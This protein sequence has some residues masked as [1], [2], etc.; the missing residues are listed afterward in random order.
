MDALIDY[1]EEIEPEHQNSS[2]FSYSTRSPDDLKKTEELR[3]ECRRIVTRLL[4]NQ[5][6]AELDALA[7]GRAAARVTS[8]GYKISKTRSQL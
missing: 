5:S 4:E 8:V 6:V 2:A 1:E 3:E 7:D